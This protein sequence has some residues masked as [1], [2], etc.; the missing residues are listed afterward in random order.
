M[1]QFKSNSKDDLFSFKKTFMKKVAKRK[2]IRTRHKLIQ[3]G[4]P[5]WIN[6]MDKFLQGVE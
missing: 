6:K 1:N 3:Q 5:S 4:V 2:K